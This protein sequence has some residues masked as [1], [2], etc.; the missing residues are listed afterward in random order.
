[1]G[2]KL[3]R[4]DMFDLSEN[5]HSVLFHLAR[6]R[7]AGRLLNKNDNVLDIGCGN[8]VGTRFLKDF[9][10]GVIG[11]DIDP[12]AVA[13][14]GS[15]FE[16]ISDLYFYTADAE[17]LYDFDPPYIYDVIVSIDVIEHLEHPEKLIQGVDALLE[18]GGVFI[19]GT[20]RK[21]DTPS[22]N[23]GHYDSL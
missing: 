13:Q 18:Q 4:L 7:F 3:R 16:D 19:C 20:P 11:I 12:D 17:N 10:S 22:R 23:K 2:K 15:L 9:C 8:G 1:M 14:A 21:Q 6:Y 5:L